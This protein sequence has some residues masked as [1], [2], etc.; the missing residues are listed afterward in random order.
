MNQLPRRIAYLTAGAGGMY[1][2]SC[3][4]DNTLA[5][6]LTKR[7]VDVQLIPT[8]TPIR[9]DEEDVSVDRVFFGGINVY[10]Q[11]K[12]SLARHLPAYLDRFLNHPA[13]I[14][15]AT[16]RDV[17]ADP[18]LL[19]QMTTSMLKGATGFQQKEVQRLL[20]WLDDSVHPDLVNFT[21]VLIAGC[22]PEIRS[23]LGVPVVVTLQGDDI[24]LDFLP[25]NYRQAALDQIRAL[26]DSVDAFV[27]HSHFYGELMGERL[28]IPASKLH[29][30]PLGIDVTDFELAD[31]RTASG[32]EQ[33]KT[34]GYLAR[35]TPEKGLH[36]LVDAFLQLR[37]QRD[38]VQLRV[39]GWLGT[40]HQDYAHDQFRKL[41]AAG[42]ADQYEYR[43]VVDREDKLKFL[44]ELDVFSVPTTYREP[45]GLFVLEAMAA[46]VPVV[47]PEHGAFPE[48]VAS[49]EGGVLVRPEDS[50]HLAHELS[51]LLD[52][53]SA[54]D[55]L[56]RAGRQGVLRSRTAEVMA[57]EALAV[58]RQVCG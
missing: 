19:G 7:G 32:D 45:K 12:I 47:V 9:T 13:L 15:W 18:E 5:R 23:R 42:L 46:G 39:A 58:Y 10:L 27:V 37:S 43:G 25:E 17:Q 50:A 26:V 57:A 44:H 53:R 2:G 3:L 55:S 14:R 16:K 48:L 41:D 24:F 21:N 34:I 11:Q 40:E 56:G 52:D 1:C 49:C 29:V 38:D 30:V 31:G 20:Q 22:A 54:R 8:Y 28:E 6:A 4:N 36:I 35:L 51:R 33:V